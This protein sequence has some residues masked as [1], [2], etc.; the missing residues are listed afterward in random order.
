MQAIARSLSNIEDGV[1]T[2]IV[3]PVDDS[4]MNI[5]TVMEE[6]LFTPI[7]MGGRSSLLMLLWSIYGVAPTDANLPTGEQA[8]LPMLRKWLPIIA[9]NTNGW[10]QYEIERV[11]SALYDSVSDESLAYMLS[12]I[13]DRLQDAVFTN[14]LGTIEDYLD[15]MSS[16]LSS[17]DG[18]FYSFYS[19]PPE[20]DWASFWENL[21][22][23]SS[24][25]NPSHTDGGGNVI[26]DGSEPS[27]AVNVNLNY[28]SLDLLDEIIGNAVDD[29]LSYFQGNPWEPESGTMQEVANIASNVVAKLDEIKADF[30][31]FSAEFNIAA[32]LVTNYLRKIHE[33]DLGYNENDRTRSVERDFHF[34]HQQLGFENPSPS[35]S[36]AGAFARLL[37]GPEDE[38]LLSST[39][40]A[41][42]SETSAS[43]SAATN[44]MAS[45]E[46]DVER[47]LTN[48]LDWASNEYSSSSPY[49]E[50]QN[51]GSSARS[52]FFNALPDLPEA[53]DRTIV[54]FRGNFPIFG[55]S[56]APTRAGLSPASSVNLDVSYPLADFD[57]VS[58]GLSNMNGIMEVV[59]DIIGVVLILWMYKRFYDDVS[60][61][62]FEGN[63][64]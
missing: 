62:R 20:G 40:N 47:V 49:S 46:S 43:A 42:V 4:W 61:G 16:S 54:L 24:M 56:Q 26:Y 18:N 41:F 17:L 12:S 38:E 2:P 21:Y 48:E 34:L 15:G 31:E 50:I 19:S 10:S 14:D 11:T 57:D 51:L 13:K 63:P 30:G 55:G 33:V 32:L 22:A 23:A 60:S 8:L 39:S 27:K 53:T 64:Q 35:N 6:G 1:S 37:F 59:W 28:D 52:Q 44:A 25:F 45:A 5:G 9:G 58:V 29:L 3:Y 7:G 36:I